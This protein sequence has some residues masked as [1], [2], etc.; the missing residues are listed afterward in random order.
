MRLLRG[1]HHPDSCLTRL[2]L[3]SSIGCSLI[4]LALLVRARRRRTAA[5]SAL[6][7]AGAPDHL[8]GSA[9]WPPV[10]ALI[11]VRNEQASLA[12]CL[13]ALL[14]QEYPTLSVIAIDDNSTDATPDILAAFQCSASARCQ[15][16]QA[17]PLPAAGWVG[18]AYALCQ[19]LM[20]LPPTS[21]WLLFLDADVTLAPGTLRAAV[22]YAQQQRL[23]LLSLI[24]ALGQWDGWS[25]LLLPVITKFYALALLSKARLARPPV[26][27]AAI[28]H[29]AFMLV[30]R[31][32]YDASGGHDAVRGT[33]AQD[34]ALAVQLRRHGFVTQALP[35]ADFVRTD[36]YEGLGAFWEGITKNLFV[37][38]HRNWLLMGAILAVEWTYGLLPVGLL[39]RSLRRRQG[40]DP[41]PQ[42][43]LRWAN[44]G[45][46]ALAALSHGYLLHRLG[47]PL[48]HVVL[49]PLS[50][51]GATAIF[52]DS[53]RRVSCVQGVRWKGRRIDLHA[54]AAPRW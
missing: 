29:G 45:A 50:V 30:R 32:A 2:I 8:A 49:Y 20:H 17:G 52:V 43:R 1:P 21:P 36:P 6:R 14:A 3:T 26:P 40:D 41:I 35:G 9:T 4:Q 10:T 47:V 38:A 22:G 44:G 25:R 24:P 13:T 28:A 15:V 23:D 34:V 39:V 51:V 19:G 37:V 48:R 53:A 46:V 18:K 31:T 33:T 54:V 12:R 16:V 5:T 27:E 42:R 11:P 7:A